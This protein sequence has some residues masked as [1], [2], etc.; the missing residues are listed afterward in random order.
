MVEMFWDTLFIVK[1]SNLAVTER[2]AYI[3]YAEG[4]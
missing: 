2:K 1:W 4:V 3:I